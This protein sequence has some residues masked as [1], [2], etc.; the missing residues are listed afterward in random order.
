MSVILAAAL[1]ANL[2]VSN[3]KRVNMYRLNLRTKTYRY[4]FYSNIM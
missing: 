4:G 1:E 2:K 3:D